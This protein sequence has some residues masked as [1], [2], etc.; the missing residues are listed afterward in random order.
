MIPI[1]SRDTR[2]LKQTNRSDL[3]GSLWS[4]FNLDLSSN[5]GKVRTTRTKLVTSSDDEAN[6]EI[7]VA[8]EYF[9]DKY[10]AL[11][12]GGVYQGGADPSDAFD[13]E[14]TGTDDPDGAVETLSDMEIFNNKLYVSEAE[15]I[16]TRTIAGTWDDDV[17]GHIGALTAASA[18]LLKTYGDH[19]YV[20]NA[21][22]TI[23][24]FDTSDALYDSSDSTHY[25]DLGISNQIFA[26]SMLQ[27]GTNQL[28]IGVLNTEGGQGMVYTW[29]G[30]TKNTTSNLY[31]LDSAGVVAG[32]VHPEENIPYIL[33]ARGRL[34]KFNGAGFS[35]IAR[36]P[37]GRY[38]LEGLDSQTNLRFVHPNGMC[39]RDGKILILV[40]SRNRNS[41][42][43]EARTIEENFPSGVYE[44]DPE[45]GCL[46]HKYS[47]SYSAVADTGVANLSDYG[48]TRIAAAGA[49]FAAHPNRSVTTENGDI[50]FGC[51]YLTSSDT[52]SKYGIF[53]DDTNDTTQKSGYL[54]TTQIHSDDITDYW[55]AVVAKF[56][57]FLDS[58]SKITLKYRTEESA[59]VI[60]GINWT[61]DDTFTSTDDLSDFSA[62]DEVE[63]I[64][65]KGAGKTAHITS[66]NAS[67]ATYTIVV[68][69]AYPL[70]AGAQGRA[71]FQKWKKAGVYDSQLKGN[72]QF[73]IGKPSEWVQIKVCMQHTG[74]DE[75]YELLVINKPDQLAKL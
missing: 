37:V 74:K 56:S 28:W 24:S 47:P 10:Y 30:V 13:L 21:H 16:T 53:C 36:L 57:K 60:A 40:D 72:A 15:N 19:L 26:I 42:S 61:D 68:D 9:G 29:D 2:L 59:P 8:F 69:E 14:D 41:S 31:H 17:A 44:Y 32:V 20:T 35:E 45:L 54:V 48:Q 46:Y 25:L 64:Q 65:G 12:D 1:P 33:D 22:T 75:L 70:T 4:S 18:H 43:G 3:L 38:P 62:G 51:E 71:R 6:L 34:M 39:I 49:I 23:R 50:I 5:Y 7:I 55:Q 58:G 73:N 63:V 52:T 27:A 11:T 67:E 66:I